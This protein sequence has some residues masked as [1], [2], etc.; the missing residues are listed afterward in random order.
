MLLRHR[1]LMPFESYQDKGPAFHRAYS[2]LLLLLALGMSLIGVLVGGLR[3]LFRH[4]SLLL[5]FDMVSL[6]VM[7]GG[8]TVSLGGVFV[9]FGGLVVFVS[10]HCM[11][12]CD[13]AAH[14]A[15]RQRNVVCSGKL[16]GI[17]RFR[18]R[19][20]DRRTASVGL[21]CFDAPAPLIS[22]TRLFDR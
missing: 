2:Q 3:M 19:S 22:L 8:R 17:I 15:S 12:R 1:H 13:C 5:A 11:P 6:A 9:V 4:V 20:S 7:F 16:N 10:C 14:F 21:M 18:C